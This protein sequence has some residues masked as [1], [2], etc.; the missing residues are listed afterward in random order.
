MLS[1]T[2]ATLVVCPLSVLAQWSSELELHVAKKKLS[3]TTYYGHDRT[4]S[5][6]VLQRHDVVLTT[7]GTLS[8]EFAASEDS[9][10]RGTLFKRAT[11]LH[12][13]HW[14]RI[15]L[16][17]AHIIKQRTTATC[18]AAA[19]LSADCRWCVTGTP[20]Q[21]TLSDL[22][23]LLH[24]LRVE[25]WA[26]YRFWNMAVQKPFENKDFSALQKLHV[27]LRPLMLRRIKSM[28][29]GDG[30]PLV[31]LPKKIVRHR[32]AVVMALYSYG[33]M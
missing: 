26:T 28:K 1:R 11:L 22:F 21:N 6:Q 10:E 12:A 9:K 15:I 13:M 16:D 3:V 25:P 8:A 27:V 2:S 23:S 17:E 33:P 30:R 14:A 19:A 4:T 31:E 32:S 5:K 20:I 18:K 24:F 7:Y 29:D